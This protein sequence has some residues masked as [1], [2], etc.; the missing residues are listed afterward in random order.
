MHPSLRLFL[1]ARG[2]HL[3]YEKVGYEAGKEERNYA[4]RY[5]ML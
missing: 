2:D 4:P 5:L 1:E 3:S